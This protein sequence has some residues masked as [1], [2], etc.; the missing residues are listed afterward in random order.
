MTLITAGSVGRLLR[1]TMPPAL[2]DD[3]EPTFFDTG[4]APRALV[5]DSLPDIFVFQV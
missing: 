2:F 5:L 3:A 1:P 4:D